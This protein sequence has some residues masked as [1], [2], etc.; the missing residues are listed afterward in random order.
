MDKEVINLTEKE[1]AIVLREDNVPEIYSPLLHGEQC[2]NIRFTLAF[3]L[4]AA[5]QE[6][7][8]K[9]FKEFVDGL[10]VDLNKISDDI[11]KVNRSKFTIIDGEKE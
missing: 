10:Q 5:E 1:G 8:I 3:I 2:D 6:E 11:A 9:Q 7:W 4:Y